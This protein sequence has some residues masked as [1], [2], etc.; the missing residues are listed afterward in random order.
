MECFGD[1]RCERT[2]IV[3]KSKLSECYLTLHRHQYY[4]QIEICVI[5]I[6]ITINQKNNNTAG[7]QKYLNDHKSERTNKPLKLNICGWD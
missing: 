6:V 5:P 7:K 3:T 4:V 2:N 1:H